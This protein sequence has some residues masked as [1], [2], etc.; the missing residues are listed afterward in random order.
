MQGKIGKG[1]GWVVECTK[2]RIASGLKSVSL[3]I[4]SVV[5]VTYTL[6]RQKSILDHCCV[7]PEAGLMCLY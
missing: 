4:K 1:A 6:V 7:F 2:R 3:S 5:D